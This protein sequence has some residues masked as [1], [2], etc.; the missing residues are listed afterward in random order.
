MQTVAVNRADQYAMIDQA[1]RQYVRQSVDQLLA[2]PVTI[3]K[4][5][6]KAL[7]MYPSRCGKTIQACMNCGNVEAMLNL[8]ELLRKAAELMA[9]EMWHE[10]DRVEEV[11]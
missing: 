10:F 2:N 5:M 11:A 1:R 4:V 8:D 3:S 6:A 7:S 9:D